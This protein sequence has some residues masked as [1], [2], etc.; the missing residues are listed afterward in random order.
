MKILI[1]GAGAVGGMLGGYLAAAGHEVVWWPAAR[2]SQSCAPTGSRCG[3]TADAHI[4]PAR[5]G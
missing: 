1:V 5:V 3:Q 2:I 4:S